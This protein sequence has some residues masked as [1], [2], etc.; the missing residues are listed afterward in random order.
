[1]PHENTLVFVIF[2]NNL[3][4]VSSAVY[5]VGDATE[6]LYRIVNGVGDMLILQE[7]LNKLYQ[8]SIKLKLNLIPRN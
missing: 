4:D 2:I 6:L 8:W 3:L 7:D 1:M 5:I